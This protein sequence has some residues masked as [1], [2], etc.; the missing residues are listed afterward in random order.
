MTQV[1]HPPALRADAER[2]RQC[3]IDAAARTFAE[4]G[5]EVPMEEIARAA[6]VGV[7]TLYRR[8]PDRKAL[9]IAVV[10]QSLETLITQTE[11]ARLEE[12]RA[13]DALVRCTRHSRELSLTVRP[14]RP[15]PPDLAE[16][17]RRE[18]VLHELRRTLMRELDDLV[19]AAQAEGTMRTDVGTGDVALLFIMA[20]RGP[21]LADDVDDLAFSRAQAVMLDGLSA[22]PRGV[23]PGRPLVPA[24][25]TPPSMRAVSA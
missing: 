13:W 17:V 12:P 16:A 5:V 15:L 4:N 11:A 25:L 18:P 7:G 21:T 14:D 6:G 20:K 19:A 1:Q 23:L 8:F 9:L 3:L 2:N 10:Q 22:Q 24:D